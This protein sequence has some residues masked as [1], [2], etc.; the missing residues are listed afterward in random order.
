[1]VSVAALDP[2]PPLLAAIARARPAYAGLFA[3]GRSLGAFVQGFAR[4]ELPAIQGRADYIA[5]V[6][7]QVRLAQGAQPAAR[8]RAR[9]ERSP[10][11]FTANHLCLESM[12]LTVQS[13]LVAALGEDPGGALPVEA[14]GLIPAD[15][16]SFPVGLLLARRHQG[17]PLRVPLL[18]LSKRQRRQMTLGLPPYGADALVQAGR[19]VRELA[20]AGLIGAGERGAL[21]GALEAVFGCPEVL[22]ALDFRTQAMAATPKLWAAWFAPEARAAVPPLA[23]VA[24]ESVRTPL[25]IADLRNPDTPVS[26]LL[27]DPRLR[28]QALRRLDGV[29][30]CWTGFGRDGGSAFLWEI[31]PERKTSPLVA[32]GHHLVTAAGRRIPLEP[33]ALVDGLEAGSLVA[34]TCLGLTLGLVRGLVQV[35]GFNQ[36]D[37]LGSIQRGLAAALAAAGYGPW[38]ERLGTPLPAMLTAG[39]APVAAGYADGTVTSAGGFELMAHGGLDLAELARMRAMTLRDALALELPGIARMVLGAAP[40]PAPQPPEP[41]VLIRP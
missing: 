33:S 25:L 36:V 41:L 5:Q 19:R 12:P 7:L 2:L 35:G 9:L 14:S 31:T 24:S 38:A 13:M 8:V 34:T 30:C 11:V 29:P 27:F 3:E 10:L 17:K 15:N 20:A 39:F 21:D 22:G 40:S 23:Y 32:D 16:Q 4:A 18:D 1:M 6:E 26:R 37:Y 28:D